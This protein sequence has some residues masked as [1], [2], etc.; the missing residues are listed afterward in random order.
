MSKSRPAVM[1][2]SSYLIARSSSAASSPVASKSPGMSG[3]S[4]KPGSRMNLEAS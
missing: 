2:A 4:E 3:A 1:N